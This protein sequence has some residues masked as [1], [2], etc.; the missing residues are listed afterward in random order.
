MHTGICD[1]DNLDF[2]TTRISAHPPRSSL[3]HV[4]LPERLPPQQLEAH[5]PTTGLCWLRETTC[6]AVLGKW[7][8]WEAKSICTY[9]LRVSTP[10][11]GGTNAVLC[12]HAELVNFLP[13]PDANRAQPRKQTAN[14]QEHGSKPQPNKRIRRIHKYFLR[15]VSTNLA[16]RAMTESGADG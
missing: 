10:S 14:I 15:V 12:A 4:D 8:P 11:T 5:Q 6:T 3:L 2:G 16:T 9:A 1:T 13:P 7:G